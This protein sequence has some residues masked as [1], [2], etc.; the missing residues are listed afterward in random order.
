[1]KST[2]F[3]RPD[4]KLFLLA[5]ILVAVI[6]DFIANGHSDGPDLLRAE[7]ASTAASSP[8]DLERLLEQCAK[9]PSS[10]LYI[11]IS[12]CF[13]QRGDFRKALLYLRRAHKMAEMEE[14]C[15]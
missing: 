1:M 7:V 10:D 9:S 14:T 13:E 6:Q 2:V 3:V 5:A 15:E 12:H 11:R 8:W 4:L